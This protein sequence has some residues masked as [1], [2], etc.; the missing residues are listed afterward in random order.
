MIAQETVEAT[1][2]IRQHFLVDFS[3]SSVTSE[4]HIVHINGITVLTELVKHN[5][6]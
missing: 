4:S 1:R 3:F 2:A 6:G 5:F